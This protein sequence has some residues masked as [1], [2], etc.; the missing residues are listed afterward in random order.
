MLNRFFPSVS[1]QADPPENTRRRSGHSGMIASFAG[2]LSELSSPSSSQEVEV[3][4]TSDENRTEDMVLNQDDGTLSDRPWYAMY[5]DRLQG[6]NL[7]APNEDES[8][9]VEGRR[10]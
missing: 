7:L 9:D 8:G 5:L 3:S 2:R 10:Q 1:V 4:R 6:A